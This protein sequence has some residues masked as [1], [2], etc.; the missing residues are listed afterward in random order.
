MT[1]L[2]PSRQSPRAIVRHLLLAVAIIS[3]TIPVA[4][5]TEFT[6]IDVPNGG[7]TLVR[8]ISGNLAVGYDDNGEGFVYDLQTK[9]FSFLHDPQADTSGGFSSY[10]TQPI[11][12]SDNIVVGDYYDPSGIVHGFK[13]DGST[14]TTIDDPSANTTVTYQG[15]VAVGIS[16][17]TIYGQYNVPLGFGNFLLNGST[18]SDF[19]YPDAPTGAFVTGMSGNM[20]VGWY[21]ANFT[22]QGFVYNGVSF[23]TLA[24]PLAAAAPFGQGQTFVTGMSGSYIVGYYSTDAG[25]THH[26]FVYDGSK[27]TTVDDPLGDDDTRIWGVSGNEIVGT[28]LHQGYNGFV[29]TIPEPS[30]VALLLVGGL[31]MACG[32]VRRRSIKRTRASRCSPRSCFSLRYTGLRW[33]LNRG[34]SSIRRARPTHFSA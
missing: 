28:Y 22:I 34:R 16:G 31:V 1:I 7:E 24:D 5:A 14:Y 25:Q 23:S 9:S 30:S 2:I 3:G 6:T 11:G 15:T 19:T 8:G 21:E 4:R 20:T 32:A 33:K 12:I 26:G 29:A 27:F 17:G 10:G 18:F 13:F